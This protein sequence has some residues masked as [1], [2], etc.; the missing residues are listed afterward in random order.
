[1]NRILK[2]VTPENLRCHIAACPAVFVREEDGKLIV[3]GKRIP[4]DSQV[5]VASDEYAVEIDPAF[6]ENVFGN[7]QK[8]S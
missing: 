2:N 1:M 8:N 7:N 6:F 4:S 3:V 5:P